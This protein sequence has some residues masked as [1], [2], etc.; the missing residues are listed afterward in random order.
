MSDHRL[1]VLEQQFQVLSNEINEVLA[2]MQKS[3]QLLMQGNQAALEALQYQ[4]DELKGE[5]KEELL[6]MSPPREGKEL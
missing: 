6:A 5:K 2:S 1:Q 3:M 4:I